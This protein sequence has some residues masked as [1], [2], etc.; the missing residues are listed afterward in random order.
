MFRLISASCFDW[1]ASDM[2]SEVITCITNRSFIPRMK[3]NDHRYYSTFVS[4]RYE[5]RR[6]LS[7]RY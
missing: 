4:F 2:V 7:C 5:S 3:L 6:L 1:D